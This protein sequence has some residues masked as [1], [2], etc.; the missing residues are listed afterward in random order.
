MFSKAPNWLVYEQ[1]QSACFF[2]S[3]VPFFVGVKCMQGEGFSWLGMMSFSCLHGAILRTP[4]IDQIS[5][6]GEPSSRMKNH[7]VF[8]GWG[9]KQMS[10][11]K[12]W[13]IWSSKGN[14]DHLMNAWWIYTWNSMVRFVRFALW[15]QD[16][17]QAS[18]LMISI[19]IWSKS[20]HFRDLRLF[21]RV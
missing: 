7:E 12:G 18:S 5:A 2:W 13:P 21:R 16:G 14:M 9:M 11:S 17:R 6:V 19:Q 4:K 8:C 3:T 15:L 20:F 10:Q 1:L